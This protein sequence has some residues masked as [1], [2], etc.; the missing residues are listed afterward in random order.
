V[1][2]GIHLKI[3]TVPPT[4]SIR[5]TIDPPTIV[6]AIITLAGI[7]ASYWLPI[8]GLPSPEALLTRISPATT[9]THNRKGRPLYEF[10]NLCAG[11][12]GIP[13]GPI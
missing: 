9:K 8:A 2:A 5:L 7:S 13:I 12:Q 10:L 4:T 3:E 6:L 1:P 11:A